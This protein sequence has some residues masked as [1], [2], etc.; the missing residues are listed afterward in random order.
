MDDDL[1]P[2][3]DEEDERG[4][5]FEAEAPSVTSIIMENQLCFDPSTTPTPFSTN[6]QEHCEKL[7][8]INSLPELFAKISSQ[9]VKHFGFDK[10]KEFCVSNSVFEN[11]I[12]SI[13]LIEPDKLFDQTGFQNGNNIHSDLVLSFEQFLKHSKGFD[14]LEKSLELE[15]QQSIFSARKS[16]DS[17]VF[18]ENCFNLSSYR[19][20]LITGNLFASTCA[21][22]EFMVKALLEHKSHRVET[23]FCDFV[24]KFDILCVETD[25][26]WRNLRSFLE[27]CVVL[28]FDVILV[29]NTFFERHIELLLRLK[30]VLHVLG[31]ETLISD[32]NKYI[33]CTYDPG[34]LMFVLSVQDKQ[35]QPQKS[36]SI[37]HAHQPEIWR[38]MYSR[39]GAVHGCR[40]DDHIYYQRPRKLDDRFSSNQVY[41]D[42]EESIEPMAN[43]QPIPC[44][45]QKHLKEIW[46]WKKHEPK[47]FRPESQFDFVH[48][49]KFLKLALSHSLP[50][51][52]TAL[53]DFKTSKPIFGTQFTCLVF[54]HMLD[55]YPKS[56]D[57]VF[58]ELRIQKPFNYFF[59]IFDVVSIDV[60]KEQLDPT[61]VLPSN[62]AEHTARVIPS[63]H[64]IHTDHVFPSDRADQTVRTVPSYHP[65]RTAR[66]V[67]RIDPQTSGTEL[68]LQPQ[69]RGGID[70]PKSLLSQEIQHYKTDSRARILLGRE[71]SKDGRRF[72]L[73]DLLV[74]TAYPEGCTDVLASVFDLL[75]DFSFRYI[76]KEGVSSCLKTCL[77]PV[78]SLVMWIIRRVKWNVR[79]VC[80][81]SGVHPDPY[82]HVPARPE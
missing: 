43:P 42:C 46:I 41:D 77:T 33:S 60:L 2:I 66:A 80:G 21:L 24:L 58:D 72:S 74:R 59:R 82:H 4:Q 62:R 5:T 47:L 10:V 30:R 69:P 79:R 37:D 7:D 44:E 36:E 45:S 56:L 54:T 51:G 6:I 55:D 31:K 8:L 16:F 22:E 64:S 35:V 39:D 52:F 1:G 38:C 13:K 57:P 67:H 32:L 63:D 29:Y 61:E 75:M 25:K 68:R 40:R 12:N 76:T 14:H 73:M 28:S 50:I 65:D 70:R 3:F 78:H 17:F 53:L 9:D 26:L 71:E 34:I 48:V 23:D 49:E 81:S 15:L 18:K 11:M 19:H 27:N 20:A